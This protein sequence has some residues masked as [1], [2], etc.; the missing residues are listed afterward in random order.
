MGDSLCDNCRSIFSTKWRQ[1]S[2][3]G[4]HDPGKRH[5]WERNVSR[6]CH[7]RPC[8]VYKGKRSQLKPD[9]CYM[10]STLLGYLDDLDNKAPNYGL[11]VTSTGTAK[12][13]LVN[14]LWD[15]LVS[16]RLYEG[17]EDFRLRFELVV[18]DSEVKH[19]DLRTRHYGSLWFKLCAN[20]DSPVAGL[21]PGRPNLWDTSSECT[22]DFIRRCISRCDSDHECLRTSSIHNSRRAPKRLIEVTDGQD[23][24]QIKLI[25]SQSVNNFPQ[26]CA[27][28]YCWGDPTQHHQTKTVLANVKDHETQ[29]NLAS[30]PKTVCD[31]ILCCQ[32]LKLTYIWIDALC[33]IQDDDNDKLS[34]IAAMGDIYANAYLTIAASSAKGCSD[35]FLEPRSNPFFT[36]PIPCF[37]GQMEE[38]KWALRGDGLLNSSAMVQLKDQEHVKMAKNYEPLHSRGWTFQESMLS[39]RIIFYSLFQP[40][41]ICQNQ[42]CAGGD[43]SPKEYFTAVELQEMFP[44]QF[45]EP[46]R[47]SGEVVSDGDFGHRWPWAA[48]QYSSRVLSVLSDKILAIHAVKDKYKYGDGVYA[49]G[50]WLQSLKVDFLW[51]TVRRHPR[52]TAELKRFGAT[53]HRGRIT[54]IPSWSWLSF[55]GSVRFDL[56]WAAFYLGK[57]RHINDVSS[58]ARV[59]R[60]PTTDQFGRLTGKPLRVKGMV[61]KVI[62][63]PAKGRRWE[64][65]M[66]ARSC[67]DTSVWD[68]AKGRYTMDMDKIAALKYRIGEVVF[69]DYVEFPEENGI[70]AWSHRRESFDM[71]ENYD[72][73]PIILDCLIVGTVGDRHRAPVL[74][75]QPRGYSRVTQGSETAYGVLVQDISGSNGTEKVRVGLFRGDEGS[76]FYFGD[77]GEKEFDF[78]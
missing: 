72:V 43:P 60:A 58:R 21:I 20:Q 5:G 17:K 45:Q 22:F 19:V 4:H 68:D 23:G 11:P 15:S 39:R 70:M 40:Y 66:Q 75:E 65:R 29:I 31:A 51:S 28:S 13:S 77:A 26:Y 24:P 46:E 42:A 57:V 14:R 47:N 49:A 6:L 3:L 2:F 7:R 41:W 74:V 73:A 32:K 8:L 18:S 37:K 1:F 67:Y 34:E 44:S 38:V 30:L 50:V 48:E 33:M 64:N 53:Y 78:V 10:C 76:S 12:P 27:L 36:A 54:D 16:I 61:K 9:E 55:D 63:I 52:S 56:V 35:G 62:V 71:H 69:D 25:N 59:L